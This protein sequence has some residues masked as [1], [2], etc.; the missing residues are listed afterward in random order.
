MQ[1][2][3]TRPIHAHRQRARR[4]GGLDVLDRV[5]LAGRPLQV[6]H[7]EV[8]LAHGFCGQLAHG[9]GRAGRPTVEKRADFAIKLG[10]GTGLCHG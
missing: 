9:C 2:S 1:P 3:R 8:V 10:H 6:E 5:Q 7:S 4:T